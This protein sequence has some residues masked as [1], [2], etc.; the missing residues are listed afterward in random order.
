MARGKRYDVV[1]ECVGNVKALETAIALTRPGGRTVTV[2]LPR[3]SA[4]LAVSPLALVTEARSL[5]GSYVGSGN[6]TRDIQRFASMFLDGCLPLRKLISSRIG[7]AEINDAMD[8]LHEGS[9]LRQ[10]ID[11]AA[12]EEPENIPV[13]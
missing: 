10:I 12:E 13:R 2:G 8:A 1:V 6:P 11:L 5:I 3:P 4:T 9:V 7:L